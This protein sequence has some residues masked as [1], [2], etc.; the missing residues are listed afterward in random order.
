MAGRGLFRRNPEADKR[1]LDAEIEAHLKMAAAD[2]RERGVDDAEAERQ[3]RREFGN[4]V[5]VKD[6]TREAWGW[7]WLERLRQDLR[8]ALRQMR[9]SWGF[10]AA[11]IGTLAL[12]MGAATA[13]FTVIDRVMLRPLPYAETD[14]LVEIQEGSKAGMDYL[15]TFLDIAE[16]R[17]WSRGFDGI[18]FYQWA[19]GRN[20]LEG[21]TGSEQIGSYKIS[22]N[23]FAV[24]GVSPQMG[25]D[26]RSEQDG[27]A[28]SADAASVILSDGAWR[29]SFGGDASIVGKTVK[30][31]GEPYTVVG[32]MPRGF[33]F[34]FDSRTPQVWALA[35]HGDDERG[36]TDKT[37]EYTVIARLA[38]GVKPRQAKAQLATLQTEVVKGYIDPD[39]RKVRSDIVLKGYA[40]T[41]VDKDVTQALGMLLAAAGV[42]WLIACV[43]AT[44]L[45]LA[46]AMVRQREI[47]LR[48]AL[49]AG[50]GRIVQQFIVE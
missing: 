45:L 9:K 30:I 17:K 49:G 20:F 26:F 28:K 47:A 11:V 6:V 27:F 22:A 43:N 8:Y 38:D 4:E 21:N 44:N 2:A 5:L 1:E 16:W 36:R 34:P 29:E 37:P 18:A 25:R 33:S 24:L 42:L 3:A 12:G 48:G 19:T 50:R 7:V 14:R 10:A 13:M 32:V 39:D 15:P 23:L 35:Q 40:A 31:S 41:L 46:R